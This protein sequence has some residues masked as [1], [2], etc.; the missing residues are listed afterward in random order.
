MV[1]SAAAM[2]RPRKMRSNRL[3]RNLSLLV[4]VTQVV[5]PLSAEPLTVTA[6]YPAG[7]LEGPGAAEG[8]IIDTVL[9]HS[10]IYIKRGVNSDGVYQDSG[11]ILL[12]SNYPHTGEGTMKIQINFINHSS[13]PVTVEISGRVH[14]SFWFEEDV[15]VKWTMDAGDGILYSHDDLGLT[16]FKLESGDFAY[17][18]GAADGESPRALYS[19]CYKCGACTPKPLLARVSRVEQAINGGQGRRCVWNYSVLPRRVDAEDFLHG[20]MDVDGRD[21]PE[22]R[23]F[24]NKARAA[25]EKHKK[26]LTGVSS[27]GPG[28]GGRPSVLTR[29]MSRLSLSETPA[30]GPSSLGFSDLEIIR[31]LDALAPVR[32][33]GT[34]AVDQSSSDLLGGVHQDDANVKDIKPCFDAIPP[35]SQLEAKR[36]Q[37]CLSLKDIAASSPEHFAFYKPVFLQRVWTVILGEGHRI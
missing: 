9:R 21:K 18:T 34:Q 31:G 6:D 22:Q 25:M 12:A 13:A 3:H 16:T 35:N 28:L 26:R 7:C 14:F 29:Q 20:M 2:L 23:G 4:L 37:A 32:S 5:T 24:I 10:C 19:A 33:D 15:C 17:L 11:G 30:Q 36:Y 27:A 1:S 8:S